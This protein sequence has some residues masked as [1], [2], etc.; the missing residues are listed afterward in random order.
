[1]PKIVCECKNIIDLGGI[2][3]E[4]QFLIISDMDFDK[5]QGLVDAEAIY[6]EFKVVAKCQKCERLHI[7]W[8]GFDKT[9]S[10]YAQEEIK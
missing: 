2:P 1:M 8:N 3:S 9:A 7:F 10:V 6:K 4:N 5:F